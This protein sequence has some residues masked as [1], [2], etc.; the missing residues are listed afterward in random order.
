MKGYG[1][2]ITGKIR[3]SNE[4]A[5]LVLNEALGSLPN[6]YAVADGMGGHLAGEIASE[7]A[8]SETKA[9]IAENNGYDNTLDALSDALQSANGKIYESGRDDSKRQGMGTTL[10][11]VSVEGSSAYIVNVGDSRLYA[12]SRVNKE[13]KQITVDHSY[14]QELL[15]QGRITA[16]EAEKHP[17]KNIITRALGTYSYVECDSFK[18]DMAEGDYLLMCSD[19]LSNMLANDEILD[20]FIKNES[21]SEMVEGL[22]GAANEKGGIDNISVIIYG[23]SDGV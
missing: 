5:I 18:Y 8:I 4:D 12:I 15:K 7:M 14:V 6:L 10:L 3:K 22:L 17:N 13:I 23:G 2:S 16:D 1:K 11:A 19:G 21:I 9:F 20:I